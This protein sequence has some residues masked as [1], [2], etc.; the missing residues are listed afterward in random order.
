MA[1]AQTELT[2]LSKTPVIAYV[3]VIE[4]LQYLVEVEKAGDACSNPMKMEWV[5]AIGA[6]TIESVRS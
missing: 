3:R 6:W 4:K 2:K 1:K 5:D